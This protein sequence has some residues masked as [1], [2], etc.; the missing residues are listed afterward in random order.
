MDT[1][2]V[3]SSI[4]IEQ[5]AKTLITKTLHSQLTENKGYKIPYKQTSITWD[6]FIYR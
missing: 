4:T 5:T 2:Q 1:L 3:F 6:A